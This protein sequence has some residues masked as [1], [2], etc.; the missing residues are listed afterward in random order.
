MVVNRL[1]RK[2]VDDNG[3]RLVEHFSSCPGV[4]FF[5]EGGQLLAAVVQTEAHTEHHPPGRKQ[6]QGG[7][8]AGDH[9][10]PPAG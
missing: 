6:V 10:G 5:A 9:P 8:L 2:K 7:Q 4:Q 3:Q 1:A